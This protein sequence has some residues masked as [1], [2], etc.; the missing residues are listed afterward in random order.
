MRVIVCGGRDYTDWDAVKATLDSRKEKITLVLSG[1]CR[2]R[3]PFDPGPN[4]DGYAGGAD[5]LGERWADENG[6]KYMRFYPSEYGRWPAA[7]PKRNGAMVDYASKSEDGGAIVAFPGGK[8]TADCLKQAREA[9]LA[10][11]EVK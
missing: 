5:G 7:G 9:K 1:A 11:L 8:G 10:V 4:G 6:I 2:I 3:S